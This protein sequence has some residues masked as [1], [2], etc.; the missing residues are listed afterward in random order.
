MQQ[1]KAGMMWA[2]PGIEELK[3]KQEAKLE[4]GSQVGVHGL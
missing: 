2:L 3:A 1:K 4:A